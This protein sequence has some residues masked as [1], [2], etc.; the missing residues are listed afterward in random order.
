[1]SVRSV[2]GGVLL[3]Q[4]AFN[5]VS[6][7][8]LLQDVL[9]SVRVLRDRDVFTARGYF[10][11]GQQCVLE[12]LLHLSL[13]T[14]DGQ[15]AFLVAFSRLFPWL[16]RNCVALCRVFLLYFPTLFFFPFFAVVVVG[17]TRP[18]PPVP[19]ASGAAAPFRLSGWPLTQTLR[20]HT[21]THT[22]TVSSCEEGRKKSSNLQL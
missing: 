13:R 10:V 7:A 14:R 21:H 5:R 9:D 12:V 2:G 15:V 16:R 22:Q 6:G 18:S 19:A 8:N 11:G 20:T 1:M 3:D 4:A 17:S